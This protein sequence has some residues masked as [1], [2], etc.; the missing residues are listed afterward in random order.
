[1]NS[2]QFELE[3]L[4]IFLTKHC[5]VSDAEMVP[6]IKKKWLGRKGPQLICALTEGQQESCWTVDGFFRI[7]GDKFRSC[8]MKQYYP[9]NTV[10]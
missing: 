6:I 2:E 4:N 9:F 1:M 5:D 8:T 7:L 10:N 3:L